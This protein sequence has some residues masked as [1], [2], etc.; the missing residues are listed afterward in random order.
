MLQTLELTAA[1]LCQSIR[2]EWESHRQEIP[3]GVEDYGP[4]TEWVKST[5]HNIG[6]RELQGCSE[7]GVESTRLPDG[8]GRG[9]Y[10]VDVCWW[11]EREGRYRLEL[12]VESEWNP[13]KSEIEHDFYKLV[14]VKSRLKVWVCSYRPQLLNDR[15]LALEQAVRSAQIKSDDEEYLILNLPETQTSKFVSSFTVQPFIFDSQ[16]NQRTPPLPEFIVRKT[17]DSH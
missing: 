15:L 9:E 6:A 12:A 10:L 11:V 17:E 7:W 2:D 4:W 16:G 3:W 1:Q 5:F 13:H 8:R 14:D